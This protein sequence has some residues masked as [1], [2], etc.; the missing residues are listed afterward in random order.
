MSR[1]LNDVKDFVPSATVLGRGY[2][3][4]FTRALFNLHLDKFSN[5]RGRCT[6]VTEPFVMGPSRK[7]E[8]GRV[9][10]VDVNGCWHY[11]SPE[12]GALSSSSSS[13]A[14]LSDLVNIHLV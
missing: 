7:A 10:F 6:L 3:V 13:F 5:R 11:G 1:V 2:G 9:E 8:L 4:A 12:I 14:Y